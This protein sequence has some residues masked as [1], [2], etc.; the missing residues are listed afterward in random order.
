M[1]RMCTLLMML[2]LLTAL[3]AGCG[4][5]RDLLLYLTFDEGS[6]T[7]VTDASGNVGTAEVSYLFTKPAFNT[8]QDPQWRDT[9]VSGGCLLFDG[10][11]N[12]V[13]IK[14]E[15]L[16]VE[17]DAFTISAWVAPRAFEWDDPNAA[18]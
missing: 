7:T 2:L 12:A 17:G 6:G 10:C 3:L 16:S 8:V 11:S 13:S 9:G 15:V 18:D 4:G 1:R 14:P 5:E